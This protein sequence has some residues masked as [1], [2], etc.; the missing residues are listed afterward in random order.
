[1]KHKTPADK[2]NKSEGRNNQSDESFIRIADSLGKIESKYTLTNE[3]EKPTEKNFWIPISIG[4]ISVLVN[5]VLAV[6]TYLLWKQATLQ[7][8]AAISAAEST[9]QSIKLAETN[10]IIEN[11]AWIGLENVP[12]LVPNT[13]TYISTGNGNDR[14]EEVAI[15]F[16][17]HNFGKTPADS[18]FFS[19]NYFV[20]KVTDNNFILDFPNIL[21]V[22]GEVMSPNQTNNYIANLSKE[23]TRNIYRGWWKYTFVF[24]GIIVYKDIYRI[25]TDSTRFC[26]LYVAGKLTPTTPNNYMH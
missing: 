3:Y 22:C 7:S 18:L 20:N 23:Q 17:I 10:Y 8:N 19:Y 15:A 14:P 21:G 16:S 9:K 5:T 4:I 13:T 1:M 11:R 2:N 26:F 6:G 25:K 24:Y 12:Q